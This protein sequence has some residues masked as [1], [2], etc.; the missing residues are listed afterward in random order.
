M[1]D[2][3]PWLGQHLGADG[4]VQIVNVSGPDGAGFSSETVLFDVSWKARGQLCSSSL[5]L[6]MPPEAV[7]TRCFRR[8][9]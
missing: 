6:R 1:D 3:A 8:T 5:V 9:T 4:G 2:L 7:P